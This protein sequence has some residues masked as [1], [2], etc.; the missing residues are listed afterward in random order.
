M[1]IYDVAKK[2]GFSIATVSRVLNGS[3]RVSRRTRQRVLD[4]MDE[5]GYVPNVFARSLGLNSMNMI[6]IMCADVSDT[7]LALAVYHLERKLRELK[8]D[9]LLCCTGYDHENKVKSLDILLQKRVDAIFL[10][11]STYVEEDDEKNDYIRKAAKNVPV[12]VLNGQITGDNIYNFL[13]NDEEAVFDV[14]NAMIKKGIKNPIC[15]YRRASFSGKRKMK[16]FCLALESNGISNPEKALVEC[17]T[18]IDKTKEILLNF[19][20]KEKFDAILATEDILAVAAVKYAN[21]KN[22]SIPEDLNI[23]GYNDSILAKTCQPELT[24]LDNNIEKLCDLSTA[25]L[26]NVIKKERVSSENCIP[27]VLVKRQSTNF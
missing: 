18:D 26:M 21:D 16:G 3:S 25:A 4:A 6:G 24:S 23:I 14:T 22:L 8:Y 15:L 17:D 12:L 11:G 9:T 27:V 5:L 10:V 13:C 1:N 7:Y 20:K 19:S 2:S